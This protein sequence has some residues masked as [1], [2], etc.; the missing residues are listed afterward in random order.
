MYIYRMAIPSKLAVCLGHLQPAIKKEKW[1]KKKGFRRGATIKTWIVHSANTRQA[2]RVLNYM[3]HYF[4]SKMFTGV[5]WGFFCC[6]CCCCLVFSFIVESNIQW[7]A[8]VEWTKCIPF[9]FMFFFF[10]L[11]AK[12][13]DTY[14]LTWFSSTTDKC[15]NKCIIFSAAYDLPLLRVAIWKIEMLSLSVELRWRLKCRKTKSKF[16]TRTFQKA[17]RICTFNIYIYIKCTLRLPFRF[18]VA[19]ES[20]HSRIS[21]YGM[22]NT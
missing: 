12:W 14:A 19:S 2:D 18:P 5:E 13:A 16:S 20:Q 10:D 1:G 4:S 6:C 8:I 15:L 7:R 17:S 3:H 21:I 22:A 11:F 9:S